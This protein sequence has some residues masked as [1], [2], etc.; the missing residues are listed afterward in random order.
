MMNRESHFNWAWII[1]TWHKIS[2]KL[3]GD[4][5]TDWEAAWIQHS[6][7]SWRSWRYHWRPWT[8]KLREAWWSRPTEPEPSRCLAE[9]ARRRTSRPEQQDVKI[10]GEENLCPSIDYLRKVDWNLHS[11]FF[12]EEVFTGRLHQAGEEETGGISRMNYWMII[13]GIGSNKFHILNPNHVYIVQTISAQVCWD[14]VHQSLC[15]V[16]MAIQCSCKH[17]T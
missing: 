9:G 7:G 8:A 1:S 5:N 11:C 12:G 4:I 2:R 16:F 13:K 10:R 3:F 15:D 17:D 6:S 14:I